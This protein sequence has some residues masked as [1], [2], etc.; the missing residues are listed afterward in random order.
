MRKSILGIMQPLGYMM[1]Q[2]LQ[3]TAYINLSEDQWSQY[4]LDNKYKLCRTDFESPLEESYEIL[5][6]SWIKQEQNRDA[7]MVHQERFKLGIWLR[8]Q[9][10]FINAPN[11]KVQ[12]VICRNIFTDLTENEIS[13]LVE[14]AR[15][16]IGLDDIN[17]MKESF[18]KA[19]RGEPVSQSSDDGDG[20]EGI[21]EDEE[22]EL[23]ENN[24]KSEKKPS[25]INSDWVEDYAE[26]SEEFSEKL[27]T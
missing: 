8:K 27:Q 21:E 23:V 3:D 26:C 2:K 6:D 1:I 4:R 18:Q 19:E 10:D 24:V 5:K 13:E 25:P 16:D 15:M 17:E 9:P 20:E 11:K 12:H 22:E 14:I 7:G